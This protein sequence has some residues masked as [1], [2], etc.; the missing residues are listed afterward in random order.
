MTSPAPTTIAPARLELLLSRERLSTYVAQCSG[1]FAPAID[2][3]RWN[4]EV[5]AAL[6]QPLGHLEVALRNTVSGCL[7]ARHRRLALPGSWLDDEGRAL[8]RRA[9]ADIA[10][11]RRRVRQKGKRVSDAQTVSEL[12]F[13][14]GRYLVTRR[15]TAL[16]PDLASAFAHA[17][18]RRRATVEDPLARLHDLRNRIAH[19]QRIWNRDLVA[20][21]EDLL[22][23]AAFLDPGLPT[24]IAAT[25]CVPRVLA[26]RPLSAPP[27]GGGG[28]DCGCGG[29]SRC[30]R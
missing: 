2:L 24:W 1:A 5:S 15:H 7:T 13:G 29:V 12:S 26:G 4:A 21:Y 8:D 30:R 6:W 11:A 19:H 27:P 3:Y 17:P 16:W 14:F 10:K 23:V 28:C 22:L 9:R 18:D 25:S 20:R